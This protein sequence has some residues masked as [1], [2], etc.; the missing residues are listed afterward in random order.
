MDA[1]PANHRQSSAGPVS[2]LTRPS[3]PTQIS[4]GSATINSYPRLLENEMRCFG[5][6]FLVFSLA[7]LAIAVAFFYGLGNLEPAPFAGC[8]YGGTG[9]ASLVVGWGMWRRNRFTWI[10]IVLF[11]LLGAGATCLLAW[12]RGMRSFWFWSMFAMN[13]GILLFISFG[14][15]FYIRET[16][17]E[18]NYCQ[19]RH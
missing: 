4:D 1:G 17:S 16:F 6:F 3:R 2:V 8:V 13:Q 12:H 7:A 15:A 5:W 9:I 19:L 18:E 10:A 11:A 14:L